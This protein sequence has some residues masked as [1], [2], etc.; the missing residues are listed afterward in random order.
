MIA[1]I[2]ANK[3]IVQYLTDTQP[4]SGSKQ[5]FYRNEGIHINTVIAGLKQAGVM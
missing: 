3:R 5:T 2:D 4:G 1:F